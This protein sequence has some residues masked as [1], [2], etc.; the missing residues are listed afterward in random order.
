MTELKSEFLMTLTIELAD[1]FPLGETPAGRRKIDIFR[2]GHFEGPRLKGVLLP[3]GSDA[4]LEGA[5]GAFRQDVRLTMRCHD[6][7]VIWVHYRGVRHGPPEVL[8]RIAAGDAVAASDYYL[9]SSL[10]FE[11]GSEKYDWLNRIIAIGA[12]KME[13]GVAVYRVWEVK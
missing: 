4:L 13:P 12:G 1:S 8:A 7:A 9:R 6:D 10:N 2:G 5:D 3:G 11:T